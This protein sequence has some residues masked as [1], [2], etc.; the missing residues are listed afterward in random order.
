M[1][2]GPA[3]LLGRSG[4]SWSPSAPFPRGAFRVTGLPLALTVAFRFNS[5]LSGRSPL[6][7]PCVI[8]S[9]SLRLKVPSTGMGMGPVAPCNNLYTQVLCSQ[10]G[11]QGAEGA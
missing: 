3:L 10:L 8:L 2:E 6:H 4:Y 9:I 5:V 1:A 7:F 11:L